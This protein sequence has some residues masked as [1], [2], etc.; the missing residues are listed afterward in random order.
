MTARAIVLA[1]AVGGPGIVALARGDEAATAAAQ[2]HY[3][4]GM[5]RFD[6]ADYDGAVLDF[7]AAYEISGSP[8]LLFNLG[9]THRLRGDRERA[10]H[11]YRR[12]LA[13]VP[14]APNRD[15]VLAII[16]TLEKLAPVAPPPIAPHRAGRPLLIAGAIGAAVGLTLLG[17][18]VYLQL[19]ANSAS[20]QIAAL[21]RSNGAWRAA[22][23]SLYDQ[24]RSQ[25][26]TAAVL[27]V[28]GGVLAAAGVVITAVGW[29]R[30]SARHLAL[31]PS[32]HGA[33]LVLQGTL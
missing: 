33:S 28:A 10:L 7:D 23:Q 3:Q 13:V 14:D 27:F 15:E 29:R 9:Q 20:D 30:E 2:P 5:T 21:S 32:L 8:S 16:A 11:C 24:G 31:V 25:A 18:G 17:A 4:R 6:M 12:F 22:D 19:E 1:L 26:V